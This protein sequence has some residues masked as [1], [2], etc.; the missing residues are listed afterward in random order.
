M[1]FNA[2]CMTFN[3]EGHSKLIGFK[4]LGVNRNEID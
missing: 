4:V 3:Q 1:D 2:N